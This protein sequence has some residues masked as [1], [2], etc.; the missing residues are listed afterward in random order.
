MPFN[1]HSISDFA[2]VA[3]VYTNEGKIQETGIY[4]EI[5]AAKFALLQTTAE[6]LKSSN[7]IINANAFFRHLCLFDSE[8]GDTEDLLREL[9]K[10]DLAAVP[11]LMTRNLKNIWKAKEKLTWKV[12][13][14]KNGEQV[15]LKFIG[16]NGRGQIRFS[17]ATFPVGN[18][19]PVALAQ[20]FI[21][22]FEKKTP[23]CCSP[24]ADRMKVEFSV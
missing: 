8:L 18:F 12:E 13:I 14:I 11:S 15:F 24:C 20:Q 7:Y 3:G 1:K 23:P 9:P 6:N 5:T 4:L 22:Q 2:A 16:E 10:T 19:D 17:T 21:L